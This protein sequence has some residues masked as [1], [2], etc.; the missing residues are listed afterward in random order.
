MATKLSAEGHEVV[1]V[2]NES[3]Y[4]P[5]LEYYKTQQVRYLGVNLGASGPWHL[6]DISK[7]RVPFVVTDPDLDLSTIPSDWDSVLLW[8]LKELS[9][10]SKCGFSL[11][12][13]GVP[14]TNPSS[15]LDEFGTTGNPKYW[16]PRIETAG[17]KCSYFAYPI[18]TTFAVYRPGVPFRIDGHRTGRPYTAR[19]LPFHLV[20]HVDEKESS[21]QIPLNDELLYYFDHAKGNTF[22][23]YSTTKTRMMPLVEEFRRSSNSKTSA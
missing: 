1:F 8:G 19:H 13:T 22:G 12:D 7:S 9:T 4:P 16:D 20:V 5:L 17:P 2:D 10:H 21:F 6:P 15:W 11:E 23:R 18:D 3:T 14:S